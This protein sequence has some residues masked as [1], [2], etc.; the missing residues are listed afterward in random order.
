MRVENFNQHIYYYFKK[1]CFVPSR[2]LNRMS[3]TTSWQRK[4]T[5][6]RKNWRRRGAHGSRNSLAWWA[7]LGL[8]NQLWLSP[9]PWA[10]DRPSDLPVSSQTLYLLIDYII[11]GKD[12]C[13][14]EHFCNSPINEHYVLSSLRWTCVYAQ[15]A[16]SDNKPLAGASRYVFALC[17][18]SSHTLKE[19]HSICSLF[20]NLPSS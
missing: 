12:T 6:S 4:F 7:Q 17:F 14:L 11:K 20:G 3:I 2:P 15:H 1:K 8:S 18:L 9:T 16:K 10:Q 19:K 13:F 5:K